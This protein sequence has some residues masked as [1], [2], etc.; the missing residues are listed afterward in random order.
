[1]SSERS[2]TVISPGRPSMA[3]QA[4]VHRFIS[5]CWIWVASASTGSGSALNR[6]F[7]RMPAGSSERSRRS[8]SSTTGCSGWRCRAC[9]WRRLKARICCTSWRART[10]ARWISV[11][12][13]CATWS[14]PT[15]SRARVRLPRMAASRLLKSCATPPA[16]VP[17]ASIFC[18]SRSCVSNAWRCASACLRSVMSVCVPTMRK[19][20][21]SSSRAMTM[22]RESTHFQ[23]PS[24]QR[25]R[26]SLR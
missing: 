11:R 12:L 8:A 2:A 18:T 6:V 26:C 1:M 21:P 24:L 20:R 10:A 4:L 16:R 3:C 13:S 9:V 25:T 5:T 15:S 14:G 17:M 23:R 7:S 19:G 22:P